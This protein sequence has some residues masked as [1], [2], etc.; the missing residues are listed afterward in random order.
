[1]IIFSIFPEWIQIV[2]LFSGFLSIFNEADWIDSIDKYL[3]CTLS[4]G[5]YLQ[6]E[7]EHEAMANNEERERVE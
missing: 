2:M 1:M 6:S 3:I 5:I 7:K 4:T